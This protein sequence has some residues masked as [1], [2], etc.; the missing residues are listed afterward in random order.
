MDD[1]D[2]EDADDSE[3]EADGAEGSEGSADTAAEAV[4]KKVWCAAFAVGVC[5]CLGVGSCACT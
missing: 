5:W 1:D 3:A 2:G 4:K